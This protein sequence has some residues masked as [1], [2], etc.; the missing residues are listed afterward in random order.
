MILMP[1]SRLLATAQ[2]KREKCVDSHSFLKSAHRRYSEVS[3]PKLFKI[4]GHDIDYQAGKKQRVEFFLVFP[5][6]ADQSRSK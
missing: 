6:F 4:L 2:S 1:A 3:Y 5:F